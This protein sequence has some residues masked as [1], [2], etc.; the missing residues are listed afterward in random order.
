MHSAIFFYFIVIFIGV[1][2]QDD[3]YK[4]KACM[5]KFLISVFMKFMLMDQFC[6]LES[7]FVHHVVALVLN[8]L[9][10]QSGLLIFTLC[11]D[12]SSCTIIFSKLFNTA[13]QVLLSQQFDNIT[14]TIM[15]PHHYCSISQFE[16]FLFIF[17]ELYHMYQ[18]YGTGQF[19]L[20]TIY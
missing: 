11:S 1:L 6:R 20:L 5:N 7:S 15:G 3:L 2:Q 18:P 12:H 14:G 17:S 16:F 4:L 10:I 8:W 9:V 19:Q 13:R